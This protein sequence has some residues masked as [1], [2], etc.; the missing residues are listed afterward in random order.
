MI[1]IKLKKC[2]CGKSQP[3]FNYKGLPAVYCSECK[4]D[5][6]INVKIKMSLW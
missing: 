2:H 3:F 6:M 5:D 1:N 4:L